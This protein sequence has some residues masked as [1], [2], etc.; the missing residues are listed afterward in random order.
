MLI[1]YIN[2]NVD[3]VI[4]RV[5]DFSLRWYSVL[6]ATGFILGYLF[7]RKIFIREE[8]PV[9]TL[10]SFGIYIVLGMFIGGRLVHC[11]FYE[12]DYYLKFPLDIIKPWRGE[13]GNGAVYT[14]FRGMASHGGVAGVIIGIAINARRQKLPVLWVFDR[15]AIVLAI[16][17]C[18]IRLGNLFNSEI[19]GTQSSLPWSFIFERVSAVPKHPVQLY[20][21]ITYLAIFIIT[22]RYYH[23]RH[24]RL[25]NG[26]ILGLTLILVF[27]SRF[28]FEFI[29]EG[30]TAA[31]SHSMLKMGQFLSI[32][33]ILAG[34]GLFIYR[35]YSLA[36][37]KN[38]DIH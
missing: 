26:E 8:I 24:D 19:L 21:A 5:G 17:G 11:L 9:K 4:F 12:P 7:I 23:I 27:L 10:E 34:I 13:L 25:R 33:F 1:N 22:Y 37:E 3:P 29:K 15:F 6:M 28:F 20:E 16:A 32:P 18:F 31:D 38:E 14:G 2:W 36:K 35:R 30:Q